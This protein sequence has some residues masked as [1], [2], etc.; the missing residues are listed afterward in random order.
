MNK[1]KLAERHEAIEELKK[2]LN[3]NE[4]VYT[5][6]R[7]VSR[8]GMSRVMDLFVIRDNQPRRITWQAAK[9]LGWAYSTRPGSEGL[10]VGGCG[11]DMGFHAVYSLAGTLWRSESAKDAGYLLDHRWL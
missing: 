2:F 7:S 4:T 10:K 9:A 3:K 11:M 5:V 6:L 8:T 1:M